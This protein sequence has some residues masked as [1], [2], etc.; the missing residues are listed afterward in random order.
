MR[1]GV[2]V[3]NFGPFWHPRAVAE[4]ARLVEDCGWD[5]LFLW[6][7]MAFDRAGTEEVGD[8]WIALAAAAMV[9]ERIRLGALITPLARR[10]PWKF[11]RETV[12]LDHLS[13]GRVVA[14][15]GLGDP[16]EVEFAVFGEEPA[17]RV[18]ADRL[19]EAVE[20]V[21]GL[22]S[23]RPYSF[24]GTHHE[25][26]EITFLPAPVQTPR[27]P[28]WVAGVWPHKRPFRRAA[29][30]DGV[31]PEDAE[32]GT[33]TPER[34]REIVAYIGSHRVSSES[35][36]V[37]ISGQTEASTAERQ[38][39]PYLASPLTWWLERSQP[40]KRYSLAATRARVSAGPPAL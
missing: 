27:I 18:R 1:Y 25:V 20:V 39:E 35:F 12:S 5:G 4:L 26:A 32:T 6:D 14:G 9:T 29:R 38:L 22:W 15:I 23:G 40:G 19:D 2:Y 28:I 16:P 36:D 31:F 34:L 37:V 21:N 17:A 7:H 10:R 8:P 11:A 30:W 13:S 33:P 24:S 3:P